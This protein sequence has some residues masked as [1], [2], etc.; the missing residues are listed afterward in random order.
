MNLRNILNRLSDEIG[1]IARSLWSYAEEYAWEVIPMIV[2]ILLLL[3]AFPG[4]AELKTMLIV[5]LAETFCLWLIYRSA[6]LLQSHL[7]DLNYG[8][9]A[10]GVHLSVGMVILGVYMGQY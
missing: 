4:F 3:F 10:L 7:P 5:L 6:T 1:Q 2:G 8:Q 9:L